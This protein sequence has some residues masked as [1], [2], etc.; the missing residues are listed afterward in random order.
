M[1]RSV[2]L[3]DA[4]DVSE[5]G[6][7]GLQVELGR[8]REVRLLA[9]VVEVEE[10]GAALDLRL[11]QRR[12]R[13]LE[14]AAV[15]EVVAEALDH[16]RAHL[17]NLQQKYIRSFNESASTIENTDARFIKARDKLQQF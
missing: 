14:V 10:R 3:R 11:H 8:L 17:Q 2:G 16:E 5:R 13:H 6:D 15:E 7:D 9:E 12:R 1:F 4:E